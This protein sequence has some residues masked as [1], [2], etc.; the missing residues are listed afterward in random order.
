MEYGVDVNT[1]FAI[2]NKTS[3]YDKILK[4][5]KVHKSEYKQRMPP[6]IVIFICG[7]D[8]TYTDIAQKLELSISTISSIKNRKTHKKITKDIDI[9]K[10]NGRIDYA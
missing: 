5:V 3:P 8:G 9:V 2:K 10:N 6:E 1:I 7:L 4:D